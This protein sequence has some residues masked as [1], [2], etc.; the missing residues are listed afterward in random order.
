MK[1]LFIAP[2]PPPVTGHSL[3]SRV[4]LDSIASVHDLRVVNF[5]KKGFKEGANSLRR[6][7]DIAKVLF[8]II[9]KKSGSEIVYL[10]ISESL[11][12]NL[13]D[14]LT[15]L[16]CFHRLPRFFIHLHGGSI[17]KLLYDRYPLLRRLN[18]YFIRRMGGVIILGKSH[19]DIFSGMIDPSR[20][21]IVPNFVEDALFCTDGQIISKYNSGGPLRILYLSHLIEG[22]GYLE[23]LEAFEMLEESDRSNIKIDFAGAFESKEEKNIF[24]D[25]IL[26]YP[27]IIYHDVVRGERKQKLLQE[28]HVFC[29]PT[30]FSEGQPIS[31]LE[32]Y[33]SG[34]TVITTMMGGIVDIFMD[35]VHG[36][37]INDKSAIS[38]KIAMQKLLRNRASLAEIGINNSHEA[39][40]KYQ[41]QTFN[42]SMQQIM[43]IPYLNNQQQ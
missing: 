19:I 31:I 29:L 21:H 17:G 35:Q 22:K 6:F 43:I 10:T 26:Q 3:A 20:V 4:F 42:Q 1:I 25:R 14:L 2:L 24:L 38:V 8:A 40:A 41:A 7:W 28:A 9:K 18:A 36:F 27:E 16:I 11:A 13:K 23:L 15:Y 5:S 12:G 37:A 32:A 39:R 30:N 34:C 33:A